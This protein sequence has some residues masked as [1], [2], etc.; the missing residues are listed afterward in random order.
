MGFPLE[1]ACSSSLQA[2]CALLGAGGTGVENPR[3]APRKCQGHIGGAGGHRPRHSPQNT[4]APKITN[5]LA[6]ALSH[7]SRNYAAW[8]ANGRLDGGISLRKR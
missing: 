4:S 7:A 1:H 2:G 6:M 8:I 5:A 3:R